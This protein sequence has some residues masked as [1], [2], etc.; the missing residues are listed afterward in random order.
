MREIWVRKWAKLAMGAAAM[1][2]LLGGASWAGST[3]GTL[4][5]SADVANNC[6]IGS[7]PA[8]NFSSYDPIVANATTDLNQTG[9]LTLTCTQGAIAVIALDAGASGIHAVNHTRDG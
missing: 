8:V 3:S 5:I 2:L 6:V 7:S 9:T 4:A 1:S